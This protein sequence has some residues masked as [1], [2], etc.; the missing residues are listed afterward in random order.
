MAV[1][2]VKTLSESL[3]EE[4][5]TRATLNNYIIKNFT[6]LDQLI[7]EASRSGKMADIRTLVTEHLNHTPNSIIALYVLGK[8][9][10]E[11]EALD[12]GHIEKLINL[13]RDNRRFNIVEFLAIET[14]KH[15]ENRHALEALSLCYSN[16]NREDELVGI[17]ERLVKIDYDE[18]ELTKKLASIKEKRNQTEEAVDYYK[19]AL[20]RYLKKG[21]Y[22]P[23]EELWLKLIE[24]VPD[25][26]S[27]FLNTEN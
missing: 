17:W 24:L 7:E 11:E 16:D 26:L 21:M 25:D 2:V 5:W 3:N 10:F 4:K 9:N 6:D 1:N 23:V 19:K 8:L 27:F 20:L 22:N 15:G 18:A 13:F 12:E 14:L